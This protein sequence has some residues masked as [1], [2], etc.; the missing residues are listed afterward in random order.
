VSRFNP[1]A[2]ELLQ[3]AAARYQVDLARFL[4]DLVAAQKDWRR[5]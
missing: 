3:R 1:I 2:L 5:K 4:L